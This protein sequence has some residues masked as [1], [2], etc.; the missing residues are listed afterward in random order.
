[1][2]FDHLENAHRYFALHPA[3]ARAF[4][5]LRGE[6]LRR[7]PGRY[8]LD[9]QRLYAIVQEYSTKAEG[10]WEAHR[11]YID[12]QFML[13]GDERMGWAPTRDLTVQEAYDPAKDAAFFTGQGSEF[14]VA[15]GQFAIFFPEDA[16]MPTLAAG[17]P[18]TVRKV[19][20]KVESAA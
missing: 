7:P 18:Q 10:R 16:H 8:E 4:E 19:V 13:A 5:A 9:G 11:R 15:A 1:M 14:V 17:D 12:I 2:I 6:L 3:F 20:I